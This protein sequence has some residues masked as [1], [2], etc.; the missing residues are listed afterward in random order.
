MGQRSQKFAAEFVAIQMPGIG[1][2][3]NIG[4]DS[5]FG[6]QPAEARFFPSKKVLPVIGI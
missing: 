1:I 2:S 4:S 6:G 5:V 3:T